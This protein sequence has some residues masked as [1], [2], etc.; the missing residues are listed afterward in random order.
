[1]RVWVDALTSK[2]AVLL[3]VLAR[4]IR[5]AGLEVLVTCREYEYTCK[6]LDFLRVDYVAVGR[7][8]EGDPYDKVREDGL[9]AARLAEVVRGFKPEVLV[10]Y[11]N[12]AASRVAYGIG[13][14]Y[15]ALTD[16][17]H[18]TIPS[19]LSLP[20]ADYVVFSSCIPEGEVGRYVTQSTK[21]IQY[22]GVDEVGWLKRLEPD[23]GY[24]RSLGLSPW[25]YV[26]FR[27]AEELATYY[28]ELRIP[29]SEEVLS[30]LLDLGYEVVLLPRYSHHLDLAR[31]GGVVVVGGGFSGPSLTY[32]ARLVVTG[33]ASIARE[34]ALVGTPAITYTPLDLH[35]NRCVMDWGFPL[36]RATDLAELRKLTAELASLNRVERSE[37]LSRTRK[38]EDPVTVAKDIVVRGVS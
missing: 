9:R 16:S 36:Y 5:S 4:E 30:V 7:Y 25:R 31:R 37:Y 32:Y 3:G 2:Q 10:A 29:R 35:V 19:R 23:E 27:P 38:L 28:R 33:G 1:M 13:A 6:A 17:P 22:R 11:P 24:V 8:S 18:A 15:V 20:L 14:R 12:P 34:A 26:V 21:L